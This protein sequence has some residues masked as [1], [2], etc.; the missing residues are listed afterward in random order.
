MLRRIIFAAVV[1]LSGCATCQ[2]TDQR[3]GCAIGAALVVGAVVI[4]TN[5]HHHGA[6]DGHATI[7]TPNCATPG[8]CQ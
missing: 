7:G 3:V 5:G 6:A 2:H 8:A 4:A 1:L